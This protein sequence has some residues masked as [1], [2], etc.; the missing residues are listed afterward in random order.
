MLLKKR[1]SL[2]PVTAGINT[3][4]SPVK[5]PVSSITLLAAS[6]LGSALPVVSVI[7]ADPATDFDTYP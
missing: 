3:T 4:I 2:P 6:A 1:Y 5:V 7:F